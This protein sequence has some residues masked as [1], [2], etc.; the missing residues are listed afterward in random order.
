MKAIRSILGYMLAAVYVYACWGLFL[1]G[2]ITGGWIAGIALMGPLW[3]VNHYLGLIPQDDDAAFV[4]MGLGVGFG[5]LARGVFEAGSIQPL[6]DALPT[7]GLV[8]LGAIAGGVL[9]AAIGKSM[10]E[11]A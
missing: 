5:G 1:D 2:S 3:F 8:V 9:A 11:E 6:V 4:D 7:L 10:E